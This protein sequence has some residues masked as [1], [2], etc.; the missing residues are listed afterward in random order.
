MVLYT[1]I[2]IPLLFTI[3][4]LAA[5]YFTKNGSGGE[6]TDMPAQFALA[7][8]LMSSGD[9]MQV[10]LINEFM[11]LYMMM[12]LI[13]PITIAAYS[14]VGEKATHS[15]EPLLATPITTFELLTGKNLAA[16]IPGIFFTWVCFGIF[17]IAL[18]II[19]VSTAVQNYVMSPT[20]ILAILVIGPLMAVLA[21][22]FAVMVSSRV[23]DPRAAEQLSA[24]LIVPLMAVLFGQISGLI[25]INLQLI[26]ISIV[27]MVIIDIGAI[28]LGAKLFQRETILTRWK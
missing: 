7:C 16:A 27:V 19:G 13:I 10:F 18:P 26:L 5:L 2:L 4:P 24:L 23:N 15:L 11:L 20:W 6:T 22:N 1:V 28:Y 14:I 25:L 17:L 9:C 12:P 3:M 8:G 21:V